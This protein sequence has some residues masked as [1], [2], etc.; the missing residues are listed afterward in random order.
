MYPGGIGSLED[1]CRAG[2][3]YD[4]CVSVDRNGRS[5]LEPVWI[6][7]SKSVFEGPKRPY[8]TPPQRKVQKRVH[9]QAPK[10]IGSALARQVA[11]RRSPDDQTIPADRHGATE[12]VETRQRRRDS[13]LLD[14]GLAAADEDVDRPGWAGRVI[15]T[16]ARCT[17]DQRR[18]IGGNRLPESS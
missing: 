11:E 4:R 18:P 14:P 3:P 15:E 7:H 12:C 6:A 9:S 13:G 17:H 1:S 8:D 5:E 16:G 2:A 10:H